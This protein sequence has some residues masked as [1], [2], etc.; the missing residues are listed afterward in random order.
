[1][2]AILVTSVLGL[3]TALVFAAA[4]L[5]ATLFPHGT[6]VSAGWSGGPVVRDWD[7]GVVPVPAPMVVPAIEPPMVEGGIALPDP[8]F[9]P[10]PGDTVQIGDAVVTPGAD[11]QP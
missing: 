4:A 7:G 3:G 11:P 10:L 1:M 2:R 8:A 5:T 9:E 6:L